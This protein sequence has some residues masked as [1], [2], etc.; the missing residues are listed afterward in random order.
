MSVHARRTALLP[1]AVLPLAMAG[2]AS[3][4]HRDPHRAH[5]QRVTIYGHRGAAGYRPEHTLA[6][7]R[8]AAR[9]GAD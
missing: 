8:W 7:Y 6:S 3:T 9:M 4:R 1:A 2:A 5:A